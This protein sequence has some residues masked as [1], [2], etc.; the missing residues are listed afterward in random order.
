MN[1]HAMCSTNAQLPYDE[2]SHEIDGNILTVKLPK[3]G[4]R[5]QAVQDGQTAEPCKKGCPKIHVMHNQAPTPKRPEEEMLFLKTTRQITPTDDLK[6]SLEV[7]FK[8]PR[9]YIP[10]PE[11]GPPPPIIIPKERVIVRKLDKRKAR[12]KKVKQKR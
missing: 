7:E 1:R 11:P 2:V 12:K 5:V 10:L 4:R 3:D 8:S 9:N 6:H